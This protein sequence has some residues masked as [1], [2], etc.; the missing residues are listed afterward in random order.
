MPVQVLE[1]LELAP[2]Q[3]LEQLELALE[4]VPVLALAQ[5]RLGK[6][7]Y[8]EKKQLESKRRDRDWRPHWRSV[9]RRE[10]RAR[11]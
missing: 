11:H 1:Q 10:L 8:L 2:V 4:L 9:C 7:Q 6:R 5:R 3:V